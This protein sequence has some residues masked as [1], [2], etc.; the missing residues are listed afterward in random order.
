MYLIEQTLQIVDIWSI[1]YLE[2][3]ETINLVF[4]E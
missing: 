4:A 2:Q 3:L 1:Y